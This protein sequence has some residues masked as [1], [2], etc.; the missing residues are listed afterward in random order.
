MTVSPSYDK[1]QSCALAKFALWRL[2]YCDCMGFMV[3]GSACDERACADPHFS[4]RRSAGI[5]EPA[6]GG[7]DGGGVDDRRD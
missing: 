2:M 3:K 6:S 4:V 1:N 7:D 5:S